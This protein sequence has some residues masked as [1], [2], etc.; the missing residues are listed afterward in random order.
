MQLFR[1]ILYRNGTN[2]YSSY[3]MI[4]EQNN[5]CSSYALDMFLIMVKVPTDTLIKH[6]TIFTSSTSKCNLVFTVFPWQKLH[7]V[8]YIYWFSTQYTRCRNQQVWLYITIP[9][10]VYVYL[11]E[12]CTFWFLVPKIF[13]PYIRY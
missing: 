10:V 6:L 1:F 7:I 8:G 9:V 3:C 13:T 11:S 2:Q 4:C 5:I 12:V